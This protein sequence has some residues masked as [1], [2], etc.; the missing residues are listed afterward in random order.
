[1]LPVGVFFVFLSLYFF[2]GVS[3]IGWSVD[4]LK[5]AGLADRILLTQLIL[6]F[7][8][9]CSFIKVFLICCLKGSSSPH[10]NSCCV[11]LQQSEEKTSQ[12]HAFRQVTHIRACLWAYV[13][14]EMTREVLKRCMLQEPPR[15]EGRKRRRH[16]LSTYFVHF[17][18][19][20]GV[21]W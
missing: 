6:A 19:L 11:A 9:V 20:S 4:L 15:W 8:S 12:S 21:F 17:H 1:M 7:L 2:E 3:G 18:S 14:G 10:T 5:R 13:W 16:F